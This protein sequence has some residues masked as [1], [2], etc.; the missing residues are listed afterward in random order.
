MPIKKIGQKGI[1]LVET[2]LA[3]GIAVVVITALVSLAVYTLRSSQESKFLLE[4]SKLAAE[5]VETLRVLKDQ[6]ATWSEYTSLFTACMGSTAT[7]FV[8]LDAVSPD[9]QVVI[10]KEIINVS[11]ASTVTRHFYITDVSDTNVVRVTSV[12]EWEV[13]PPPAKSTTIVTDIT[14]WKNQ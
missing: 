13:G 5:Q 6:K 7:C 11:N 2:I 12:V 4:G 10:G 3:L 9:P 1:G 14:N 8:D